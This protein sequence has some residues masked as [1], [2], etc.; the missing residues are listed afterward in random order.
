MT[1]KELITQAEHARRCSVSRKS[2]T[3]WKDRGQLVMDGNL[4]DFE[5]SY[6]GERWHAS[7]KKVFSDDAKQDSARAPAKSPAAVRGRRADPGAP[8]TL[9]RGEVVR[10]L[11][12]LDWTQTF[13]WSQDAQRARALAAAEAVGL[14]AVES[15][16]EDD[17]HWGGFQLRSVAL[18]ESHGGVCFD[19]IAAGYGFELEEGDV[20][21]ESR[22]RLDHPDDGPDDMTDPITIR[23]DQL[24]LL[25]YPFGPTHQK[26]ASQVA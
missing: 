14:Q 11:R 7:T 26:P 8:V 13:E 9:S 25:A 3:I 15:P 6:K 22:Q 17:G 20:L 16:A 21:V 5:A 4:I 2:V 24:P 10:R 18:M 19:A 12:A 1:T 23:L